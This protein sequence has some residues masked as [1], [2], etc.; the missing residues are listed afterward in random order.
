MQTSLALA[1]ATSPNPP[2]DTPKLSW[3]STAFLFVFGILLPAITLLVESLTHMC[4]RD[5]FDPLPTVGHVFAVAA[6]PLANGIS[7]WVLRRSDGRHLEAVIFGQAF[8]VAIAGAY[9][10]MF[11][12]ITPLAMY[13]FFVAL[14]GIL[15][16]A[17]L[18][19]LFAGLRALLALRRL[20][21]ALARP[22]RRVVLGGLAAGLGL[23]L[24]LNA[25]AA[26]TRV[27]MY[28]ATSA[29]PE[30]SG[31]AVG[32]L[33]R[34]GQRDLIMRAAFTHENADVVN[35]ALDLLAPLSCDQAREVYLRVTGRNAEED[36]ALYASRRR[37][38]RL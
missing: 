8:A 17:P 12:P 30:V 16:L 15:P 6:V 5:F 38:G 20:R 2:F 26:L 4:A 1:Q 3:F 7:L 33:Q 18:L 32:W 28:R 22:T 11:A 24:A 34:I 14:I 35:V 19:S 25:P 27:F 37:S 36:L 13:A 23:L 29:D 9:A 31:S 21:G 10:L